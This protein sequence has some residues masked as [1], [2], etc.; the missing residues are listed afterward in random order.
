MRRIAAIFFASVLASSNAVAKGPTRETPQI[1]VNISGAELNPGKDK[2]N[3]DYVFPTR[4]Q[5]DHFVAAG[6][7]MF[8]I[9]VLADR[10]L[11]AAAPG[12]ATTE[13]WRLLQELIDHAND[14]GATIIVD[15]HQY[16]RM[17]SGLI[18][19]D[20]AATRDFA[21][22]WG[23]TARRL[24]RHRN[25]IFGLMN[26]PHEQSAAEW[27]TG[28]NAAIAAIRAS[29]ARQLILAPGS[30][31]TGAHSWTTT[32]N[33][34]VMKGIVDPQKNF[35]Y[36]A[37]QYLDRDSSGTKPEVVAGAG[38]SRLAAFTEWARANGARAFLGEFGFAA[39]R[40]AL[41]EGAAL[42]RYMKQ[43]PDVWIGGAYWAAGQWWG[44][45]M[46]SIEPKDHRDRPQL[47]VLRE[48]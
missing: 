36:E 30:Y 8:R 19:R 22:A 31:W 44:D 26:E 27:L 46:F 41:A 28:A 48:R 24:K 18:G 17:R 47:D 38:A 43:N 35:A 13:D 23:E 11:G 6:I 1:G 14:V 9:P 33:A 4:A 29:G 20:G 42:V 25:V 37:H 34:A 7:R 32:D 15:F 21:A 3:F 2:R 10:L 40:E 5:I 45:Y 16:G 39:T 12:G